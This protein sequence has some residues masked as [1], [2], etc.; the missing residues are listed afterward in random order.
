MNVHICICN[1]EFFEFCEKTNQIV[2]SD[3]HNEAEWGP[4]ALDGSEPM[5]LSSKAPQLTDYVTLDSIK[6]WN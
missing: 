5:A 3:I 4:L 6:Y 2:G 1:R